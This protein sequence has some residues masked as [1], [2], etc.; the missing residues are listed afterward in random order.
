M[1]SRK[2]VFFGE[3]GSDDDVVL[4]AFESVV[5]VEVDALLLRLNK[6]ITLLLNELIVAPSEP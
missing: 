5:S 4:V 2:V 6:V 1:V 3:S